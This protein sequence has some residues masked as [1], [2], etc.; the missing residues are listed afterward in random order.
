MVFKIHQTTSLKH[1]FFYTTYICIFD[2]INYNFKKDKRLMNKK[3][4][5]SLFDRQ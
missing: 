2:V 3:K 4:I 5:I 1:S